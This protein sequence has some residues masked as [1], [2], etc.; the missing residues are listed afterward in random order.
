[1]LFERLKRTPALNS[2]EKQSFYF[3]SSNYGKTAHLL[4]L[5]CHRV[6]RVVASALRPGTMAGRG[7][8]WSPESC[9]LAGHCAF[10][11]Y[12]S[13]ITGLYLT[14]DT[15]CVQGFAGN[16]LCTRPCDTLQF[17]RIFQICLCF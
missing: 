14:T 2:Q 1:M 6:W 9:V 8:S 17:L 13:S 3:F 12:F 10:Q 15:V 11:V 7:P 5:L 16:L 4:F